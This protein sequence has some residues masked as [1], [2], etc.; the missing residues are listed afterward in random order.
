MALKISIGQYYAAASP[1]HALDA[2]VKLWCVLTVLVAVFCTSNAAQL[3]LA[4]GF[5]AALL[6]IARVPAGRVVASVRPLMVFLAV[7]SLFNLLF[8][9]T[10]E[11]VAT[12]GPLS[13][14]SGGI[15]AAALYTARFALALVAGSLVMLTTT[16]T[17]LA[18]AFDRMLS[19]LSQVGIP[20]HEIAMV[21]SLM[22]RFVPTLADETSA[23]I[24]AQSLR[25]G[26]FDEGGPVR[27]V[28]SIVPVVVALLASGLRHADGLSRALDAR[29]YE[30]GAGRTHF[31]EQHLG[32]REV[33]AALV[34]AA[35]VAL[36]V[37]LGFLF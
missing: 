22:M 20:G 19:P 7:L 13:V 6:A 29:C 4:A 2:R 31:H 21:F 23:I 15:T 37:L 25:G 34:T 24:D 28:R 5:V 16:P 1:V 8:V 12:L 17:Q 14:T 27:R 3:L 10:G 26:A 30:G 35:F 11:V 33:V 9:R 18:D 32:A 36:L